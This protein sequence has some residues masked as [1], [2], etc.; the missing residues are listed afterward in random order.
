MVMKSDLTQADL[1]WER[2]FAIDLPIG[3]VNNL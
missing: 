2:A 1:F 3:I